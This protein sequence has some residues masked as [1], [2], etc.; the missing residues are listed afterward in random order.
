M[1]GEAE[2]KDVLRRYVAAVEAGDAVAIRGFFADNATWTLAAGELP[3][4]GSWHGR[5]AILEDFLAR[6]VANYEPGSIGLEVTGM[7]A[8][9][10]RVVV[11]WTTRA[12]TTDGRSYEN[13][14]IGVFVVENGRIVAVREYMDTLYLRDTVFASSGDR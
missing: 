10:N 6:A 7:V 4:S 9:G 8:E 5:D 2:S 3:I 11:E 1:S 13:D 12:R 14:C